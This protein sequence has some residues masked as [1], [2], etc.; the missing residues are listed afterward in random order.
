[1]LI[2]SDYGQSADI[3]MGQSAIPGLPALAEFGTSHAED[4]HFVSYALCHFNLLYLL[5]L[6]HVH[7]DL[8]KI[9]EQYGPG[10]NR[11]RSSTFIPDNAPLFCI[12]LSFI[13][14]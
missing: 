11:D 3:C 8:S 14:T 12:F 4:C 5:L 7:R 2:S 6:S 9:I 13:Q 1:M 10:S